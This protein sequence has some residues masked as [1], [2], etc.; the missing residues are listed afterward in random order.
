MDT[1]F[2]QNV[3]SAQVLA[4]KEISKQARK[5]F[6]KLGL[7]Y[8]IGTILILGIQYLA[9]AIANAI[10]PDLMLNMANALLITMLPMYIIS[11]PI[12]IFVLRT[13]PAKQIE[14]K[15]M[16][17]GQWILAFLIC[18]GGM[19]VSN[20]IGVILTQ[21]IGVIKGSPVTNGMFEVATSSNI[22]V[23][24]FI[25]VICAPIAEEILFRKL[26][27]DRTVKYGEATAVLFSGLL[28]GLFHGNL[29][30]FAYAFT[31][32]LFF[33]FVYVKT[34]NVR[35]TIY[36]HMLINFISSILGILVLKFVGEDFLSAMSDPAMVT[37]YM[38]EHMGTVLFYF[39]YAFLLVTL[40][41]AGVIILIVNLK[42]IRFAKGEVVIPKGKRFSSTIVNI[43]M[44][45]YFIFWIV[46]IIIQLFS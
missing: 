46:M 34:G 19:Y 33:G 1:Q 37:A 27:I 6:S 43:G 10:N 25:M 39:A 31:L 38:L 36:L 20:I 44:G 29:N 30:Q 45:L 11:V 7:M 22:P 13:L 9:A 32:G 17:V 42:K 16:S 5:D 2:S 23:N 40:A 12:T 4:P 14:K 35:Y 3:S 21:I 28:F 26:L 15:K 8:V 18:Y 41:I 24:F